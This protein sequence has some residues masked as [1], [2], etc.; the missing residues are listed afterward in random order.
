MNNPLSLI[1]TE[2]EIE[3]GHITIYVG[4]Y[5]YSVVHLYSDTTLEKQGDDFVFDNVWMMSLYLT[6]KLK[7]QYLM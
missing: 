3:T 2:T 4:L 6:S 1:W 7:T 5:E